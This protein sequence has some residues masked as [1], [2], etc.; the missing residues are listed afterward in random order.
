VRG[1]QLG[2]VADVV[3]IVTAFTVAHSITLCLSVL[4]AVSLPATPVEAAIALSVIAAA[5]NGVWPF[6]PGRSWGIAFGFGLLH[7]LGFARYLG[8][9]GLPDAARGMALLAF[10]LGVEIGQ[11]GV[12]AGCLPLLLVLGRR[13]V[14]REWLCPVACLAIAAIASVWLFERVSGA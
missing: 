13:R 8:E 4:G 2:V 9:L 3:R 11:L 6:L 14:Y 1:S 5:L 10:N 7:G 12:V